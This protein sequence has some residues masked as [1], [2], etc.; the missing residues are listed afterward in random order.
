VVQLI[1]SSPPPPEEEA[2]AEKAAAPQAAPLPSPEIVVPALPPVA[3]HF[4]R[5]QA[6]ILDKI[7]RAQ[8]PDRLFVAAESVHAALSSS[9]ATSA[10]AVS[11]Q[12]LEIAFP[13]ASGLPVFRPARSRFIVIY[14]QASHAGFTA[15]EGRV[16]LLSAYVH[17]VIEVFIAS[18]NLTPQ[19]LDATARA[20]GSVPYLAVT[21]VAED[22]T[23][24]AVIREFA[25][26][27]LAANVREL[28]ALGCATLTS[29][30]LALPHRA[31]SECTGWKMTLTR[32]EN[33]P[34]FTCLAETVRALIEETRRAATG[35]V[36]L[37]DYIA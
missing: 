3:A 21:T 33:R 28:I 23:A 25:T 22:A 13:V 11:R 24:E 10:V 30:V 27:R 34:T 16:M 37:L 36:S 4:M 12:D 6:M 2:V 32:N 5:T 35:G 8:E 15:P 29:T 1:E 14:D 18:D 9:F 26:Y 19:R 17:A 7:R 31:R 20:L